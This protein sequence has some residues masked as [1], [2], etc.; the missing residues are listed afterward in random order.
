MLNLLVHHVTSRL[1]KVK[2]RVCKHILGMNLNRLCAAN[3][4]HLEKTPLVYALLHKLFPN[5]NE[6]IVHTH[7]NY[8]TG[9]Y[10]NVNIQNV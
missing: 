1:S 5:G 3:L 4:A 10:K 6:A 9:S 8:V 7:L 2:S